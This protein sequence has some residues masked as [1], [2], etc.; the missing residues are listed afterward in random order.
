MSAEDDLSQLTRKLAAYQS[1]TDGEATRVF[2]AIMEG[3]VSQIRMA[4][5]L[6]AIA[7]RGPSL[8]EIVGGARAMRRHMIP[9]DAPAGAMDLCGTGGDHHGTLNISTAVSFVIAACGVPVAKHGNRAMSS[10]TGAADV[11]EALGVVLNLGPQGAER[12][13]GDAG[14]CFLFAQAHHPAMR[15]VAPVRKELGFRTIFNLLGPLSNPAGVTRQ[16]LGV[17]DRAWLETLARTLL[18]L[19]AEKAWIVHGSDGLD[20]LTLT[21][22]TYVAAL[23]HGRIRQFEV[24]PEQAGLARAPLSDIKG[25][26]A[27]ENADAILALFAGGRGAFRDIVLLNS[28]AALIVA[29]KCDSL[30][31]GAGLAASALDSG[32]AKQ[33]LERLVELSRA[34]AT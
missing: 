18:V 34:Y 14:I 31:D 4:S 24:T 23:E 32:A 3:S 7:A 9:V 6:T 30:R 25:G 29:G 22:P 33:R 28:A 20:E 5:I 2:T 13:L 27:A 1:L 12:C 16:L 19:G 8:E 10:R 11:L 21:G 26:S 17:F 15:H